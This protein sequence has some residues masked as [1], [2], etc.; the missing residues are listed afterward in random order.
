M[1]IA[2]ACPPSGCQCT[3]AGR[4]PFGDEGGASVRRQRQDLG[5]RRHRVGDL[6][7][8]GADLAVDHIHRG[9]NVTIT[10][11]LGREYAVDIGARSVVTV[12]DGHHPVNRQRPGF[13][14]SGARGQQRRREGQTLIALSMAAIVVSL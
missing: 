10:R 2:R 11:I 5:C 12:G 14:G 6:D 7:L 3:L 9:E 8:R 13:M 4:Q 1:L